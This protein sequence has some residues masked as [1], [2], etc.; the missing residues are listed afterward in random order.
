LKA[1]REAAE[2][3]RFGSTNNDSATGF[4]AR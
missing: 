2:E 3:N 1:G 4:G